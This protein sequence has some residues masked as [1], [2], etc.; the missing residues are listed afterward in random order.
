[1]ENSNGIA[2][3]FGE[4]LAQLLAHKIQQEY[5][6]FPTQ[7]YVQAIRAQCAGLGYSQ[8]VQLHAQQ[9]YQHL[10]K[11]Y[12]KSLPVLLAILGEENPNETGMF[13][14]Y[15]WVLPIA[16]YIENYGLDYFTKSMHALAQ[17]TKRGTAEYAIRPFIQ[18]YPEQA[19]QQMT[20]WAH[21]PNFHLRRLASEGL[22]PKL[23]WATKLH[24]FIHTP[25]KVFSILECLKED[26]VLFVKKIR[27]QSCNRLAKGESRAYSSIVAYMA[28]ISQ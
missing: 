7:K 22:R 4:N 2:Q 21:S 19:L 26:E 14:E 8:R 27:S 15:Y 9:L 17:V 5:P 12:T 10:P 28:G 20:K 16:K 25:Q 24:T 6:E 23:P 11:Q 3:Y 1:M 13:S 18:K